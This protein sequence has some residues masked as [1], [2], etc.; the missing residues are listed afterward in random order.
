MVTQR[1]SSGVSPKV[2]EGDACRLLY[3]MLNPRK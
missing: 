2:Q 1:S 3:R